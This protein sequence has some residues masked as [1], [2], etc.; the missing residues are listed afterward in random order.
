V[1]HS[2]NLRAKLLLLTLASIALGALPAH[3][4][5]IAGSWQGIV[6]AQGNSRILLKISK[7]DNGSL[8]ADMYF[9]DI[10][11]ARHPVNDIAFDGSTLKFPVTGYSGDYLGKMS[12]DGN[13][14]VGAWKP[15]SGPSLPLTFKRA[16]PETAW[17]I[18]QPA[19][20]TAMAADAHPS[21]EVAT[22]KPAVPVESGKPSAF[23]SAQGRHYS[24]KSVTLVD[25]IKYAY[26]LVPRQIQGAP[27]WADTTRF[28][29]AGEPDTE[30]RPNIVQIQEMYQKL[31]ADRFKLSFRR[32]NKQLSVY[33]L[34]PEEGGPKVAK[35]SGGPTDRQYILANP[36]P[37]GG[38][39]LTFVNEP[40]A[41]L[42][43]NLMAY[44]TDR[45]V[46]DQTGLT[47]RYD[48]SLTFAPDPLAPDAGT[49]PDIF[50]AVQ[51]QLGLK[52]QPTNAPVEVI[53]IDHV[54]PP[55]PN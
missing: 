21:F 37:H 6:Q 32:V 50:H 19:A 43:S 38:G 12:V 47:G 10:G 46:V 29:I 11:S 22:I 16:T 23:F 24:A 31:L 3:A 15:E 40:M 55:S 48:F 27:D 45:Q 33:A 9:L 17:V 52:L 42:V 13:S 25:L 14:I 35:S 44:I 28:D 1:R 49:A 36:G 4:Q 7:A 53:V 5:D 30:G 34:K 54:E 18:P 51:Q 41:R 8:K 20:P 26:T 2:P 39:T